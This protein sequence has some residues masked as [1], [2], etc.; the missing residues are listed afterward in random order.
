MPTENEC[1][2][3]LGNDNIVIVTNENCCI[4]FHDSFEN[5]VLNIDSLN[6]VRHNLV[7][8]CKSKISKDR[9]KIVTNKLWR[10]LAYKNFISWINSWTTIG[11]NNRIVI[12]ACVV[13]QVGQ[14]F[15]EET[16]FK[17]FEDIL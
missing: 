16:G 2:C 8:Q 14:R 12:P 15:P 13:R 3:C 4:T 7:S 11:R 9:Y 6:I 10:H 17:E 1:V 5:I